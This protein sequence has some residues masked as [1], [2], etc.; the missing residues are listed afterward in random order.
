MLNSAF[1]DVHLSLDVAADYQV[2]PELSRTDRDGAQA[3]SAT[4]RDALIAENDRKIID[5]KR[6]ITVGDGDRWRATRMRPGRFAMRRMRDECPEINEI[7]L[8]HQ[9]RGALLHSD[10]RRHGGLLPIFGLT[11]AGKTVTYSATIAGRL[12]QHGGY[13]LSLED[14]PEDLLEGVHGSGYCEQLDVEE[15][16]GYERAISAALRMF[17]AKDTSILG[18]GEILDNPSAAQLVR[19]AGDGHLVLFTIH[20]RTIQE[21]MR[22]LV[23][24]A[25][26]GGEDD[27]AAQ[28]AASLQLAIHQ[29]F[30][31]GELRVTL[32]KAE[33]ITRQRIRSADFDSL[34]SD[35][36]RTH[37]DLGLGVPTT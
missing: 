30:E 2:W 4:L 16:G 23:S 33:H 35:I 36:E 37:L 14:P 22:R 12:R 9:I 27:A 21:G 31:Q 10:L 6:I 24:M 25:R 26:A 3:I 13:A 32:L 28:I 1:T 18:Y 20:A 17:P 15:L 11:G 29:K 8:P 5:G 34:K 19:V 7:G